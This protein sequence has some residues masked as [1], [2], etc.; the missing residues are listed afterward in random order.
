MSRPW[1]RK[2][3]G[4]PLSWLVGVLSTAIALEGPKAFSLETYVS[5][6]SYYIVGVVVGMV[7]HELMHRN[8]AR[9]YGLRSRYVVNPIGVMLTLITTPLPFKI[10]APGYTSVYSLGLASP[11]RER[12]GFAASVIAGPMSN[13]ALSLATLAAGGLL[14]LARLSIVLM[15]SQWLIGF[16]WVNSYLAFFNL[17]PIPPLDGS[18]IF[19]FS[20]LLWGILFIMSI[21]LLVISSLL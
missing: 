1:Y 3:L 5:V 15:A 12:R 13:I 20:V 17:L 6:Y 14:L 19:R 21:A 2:E 18:K 7:I 11:W 9:R 4:E 10:I 16:S 8:V